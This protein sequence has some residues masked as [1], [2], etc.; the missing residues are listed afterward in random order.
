[1]AMWMDL[2]SAV[3][4]DHRPVN[5]VPPIRKTCAWINP[6]DA[7]SM[8]VTMKM[9]MR[10]RMRMRMKMKMKTEMEMKMRV[11]VRMRM[12]VET[13]ME[14]EMEMETKMSLLRRNS[15]RQS[16]L[17][18]GRWS[19]P[20]RRPIQT[21]RKRHVLSQS[22]RGKSLIMIHPTWM[23][24]ILRTLT[25]L[26]TKTQWMVRNLETLLVRE[27]QTTTTMTGAKSVCVRASELTPPS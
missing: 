16:N 9:R 11:R 6:L 18:A 19:H 26:A 24:M 13:N 27:R 20:R 23:A 2:Q 17:I 4:E 1:M 25:L 8:K 14:M 7:M 15:N 5:A 3:Y 21:T 12:R 22:D 10:M